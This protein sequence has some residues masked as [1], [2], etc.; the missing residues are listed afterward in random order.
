MSLV[1]QANL[2]NSPVAFQLLYADSGL[3]GFEL[4]ADSPDSLF[5]QWDLDTVL[6]LANGLSTFVG[7]QA[8]SDYDHVTAYQ[9][10]GGV[11]WEF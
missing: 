9:L 2:H 5:Y 1:N 3:G 8:L 7:V 6:I 4:R 11:N 10:R